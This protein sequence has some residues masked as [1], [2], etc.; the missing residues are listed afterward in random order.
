MIKFT[1]SYLLNRFPDYKERPH[2]NMINCNHHTHSVY[3]DGHA[4]PLDYVLHALEKGFD[5]LG[6]TE[7]SPLPFENS[8]SFKMENKMKYLEELDRLKMEY[9]GRIQIYTGM[10]MDFIPGISEDFDKVRQEFG[11]DYLIG[12]VHLVKPEAHERLWFTDGPNHETYDDGLIQLFGND[13]RKAVSTYY[14]Q[15]NQMITTQTFEI[16]GHFDKIKMH[17][18]GRFFSEEEPWYC[19]LLSETLDLIREKGLIVEVNTRGLYKKRSDTT[20][21]GLAIL[22]EIKQLKI[23]VMINSDAHLPH[24]LDGAYSEAAAL[25]ENAGITEVMKFREEGWV[26]EPIYS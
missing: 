3:S 4:Q 16:I 25:L 10:E 13:I 26:S 15:I 23:P 2:T 11:L 5:I 6:F 22:K 14:R 17:N 8:F 24:E 19:A 9:K 18:K 12:S 20:Y 7:H 1:K 21:P